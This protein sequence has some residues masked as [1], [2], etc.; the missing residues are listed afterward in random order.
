MYMMVAGKGAGLAGPAEFP[1][2]IN[3]VAVSLWSLTLLLSSS[4]KL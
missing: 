1:F 3:Y 2:P 4:I